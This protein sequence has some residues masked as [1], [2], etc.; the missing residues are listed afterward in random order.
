MENTF[1]LSEFLE[2]KVKDYEGSAIAAQSHRP[3]SLPPQ[4]HHAAST[5]KKR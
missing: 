4:G 2:K 1:L 5:T 3:G